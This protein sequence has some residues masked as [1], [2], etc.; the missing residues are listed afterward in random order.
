[1]AWKGNR[2]R[3]HQRLV[4]FS[5]RELQWVD[6]SR[7]VENQ[8]RAAAGLPTVGW[9]TWARRRIMTSQ[10]IEV[11]VP[12]NLGDIS[13]QL[14]RIGNNINQ[15]AHMVNIKQHADIDA[16][17]EIQRQVEQIRNVVLT[18]QGQ[19]AEQVEEFPWHM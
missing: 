6:D 14:A 2:T 9:M 18:V 17:M 4:T 1:M 10:A 5:D 12:A 15:V 16:L 11:I 13:T 3:R 7:K 19:V 8:M